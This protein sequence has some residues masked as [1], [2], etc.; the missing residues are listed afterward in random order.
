MKYLKMYEDNFGTQK[1]EVDDYVF[2]LNNRRFWN[3][4]VCCKIIDVLEIKNGT[5]S[6]KIK[7]FWIDDPSKE[8]KVW[9]LQKEIE[10]KLT[11]EEVEEFEFNQTTN[12]YNL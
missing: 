1:Y 7:T 12:K 9:V 5:I 8:E 4:N 6:Y 11:P 3:L 2:L 10:R